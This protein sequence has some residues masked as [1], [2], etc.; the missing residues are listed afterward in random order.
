MVLPSQQCLD[1]I[2][3]DNTIKDI[4]KNLKTGFITY[5]IPI[6]FL[7]LAAIKN[8][9]QKYWIISHKEYK[10]SIKLTFTPNI[11]NE[12]IEIIRENKY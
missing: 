1:E 6:N 8:Y 9:Y 11:Q 4:D 3:K 12:K 5:E 10:K 7:L 2:L